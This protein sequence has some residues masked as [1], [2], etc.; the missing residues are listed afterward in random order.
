MK[1]F[2][3]NV[4]LFTT[5]TILKSWCRSAKLTEWSRRRVFFLPGVFGYAGQLLITAPVSEPAHDVQVHFSPSSNSPPKERC[6]SVFFKQQGIFFTFVFLWGSTRRTWTVWWGW[7]P[8]ENVRAK[9]GRKKQKKGNSTK[10]L[11]SCFCFQESAK[12]HDFC[13]F[14]M[15]NRSLYFWGRKSETSIVMIVQEWK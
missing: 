4:E 1:P 13:S 15:K 3:Q 5:S 9:A 11:S 6:Q 14:L 2:F 8:E 10:C 12:K 7:A